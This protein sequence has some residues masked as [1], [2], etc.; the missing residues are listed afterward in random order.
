MKAS[1]FITLIL[2]LFGCGKAVEEEIIIGKNT[3]TPVESYESYRDTFIEYQV[4][5]GGPNHVDPVTF[6]FVDTAGVGVL[7]SCTRSS[8]II[9]LSLLY[10]NQLT[11]KSREELVFHELGHCFLDRG[12]L[13]TYT[14]LYQDSLMAA[15][16]LG[17][18]IYADATRY[19]KY[20]AELFSVPLVSFNGQTFN[21][22]RYASTY[23]SA[24]AFSVE[25]EKVLNFKCDHTSDGDYEMTTY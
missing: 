21:T 7:G 11:S 8:R 3:G 14:G 10:W 12:H 25:E 1:V 6:E 5:A 22:G 18:T 23:A 9:R 19:S 2:L 13:N 17:P 15:Y 16:H 4:I 20:I 24:F